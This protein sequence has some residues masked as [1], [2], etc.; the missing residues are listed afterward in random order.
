MPLLSARDPLPGR[1]QRVLVAGT[2]GAGKTTTARRIAAVLGLPHTEIDGLFHGPAWTE[3][4]TFK[5]DVARFTAEPSWVTEWQYDS[6]RDLLADRADLLVWLHF[7]RPVVMRQVVRRTVSRR[8]RREHL[9]NGNLEPAL[10][11]LL[12]DPDHIIRWAWRTH[13]TTAD[14]VRQLADTHLD[15]VVVELRDRR[16]VEEWLLGPL[17]RTRAS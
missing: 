11:T 16:E 2:S 14:R 9:W 4:A 6:V 12:T 1:P 3:R 13:S 8:L 5:A 10:R 7:R 15:L 17:A